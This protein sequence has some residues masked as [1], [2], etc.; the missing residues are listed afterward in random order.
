MLTILTHK[1]FT[2]EYKL[3]RLKRKL[4]RQPLYQRGHQAVK[5][6]LING[7]NQLN[8]NY[9]LDP[10]KI[11]RISEHVHVLS[12]S[13]TVIK[14]IELKK[15]GII[16]HL[17]VGPNIVISSKDCNGLL[18]STYIDKIIVP[19][20]WVLEAYVED[21][22]TIKDKIF[23]WYNGIDSDFWNITKTKNFNTKLRVLLYLKFPQKKVLN[24]CIS[25][26]EHNEIEY[27]TIE[28][29]KYTITEFREKLKNTDLVIYFSASESQGIALFEIWAT[30]TPTFVWNQNNFQYQLRNYAS[31]S[32]PYLTNETGYFFRDKDEFELLIKSKLDTSKLNPV[33][34]IERNGT[35]SICAKKFLELIDY[36]FE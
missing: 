24:D 30:N 28:Y 17:T 14:C 35:N 26:L 36:N 31:S 9:I 13:E 8:V 33:K 27:D 1:S 15:K 16:K 20:Q 11:S 10:T 3:K 6:S 34:W 21:N 12:G 29:G 22:P 23:V 25:S 7:L 19:S 2:L 5:E 32:A 4:F 18:A